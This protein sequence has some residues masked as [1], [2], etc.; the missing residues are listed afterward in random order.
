MYDVLIVGC[1]LTGMV[2][3]R[4]LAEEGL[5]V[6][7]V[8]RRDHIGGNMYDYKDDNGILVQKYGPHVFFTDNKDVEFFVNKYIDTYPFYPECRTVIE[9]TAIPM[10]FNFAS[11]DILYEKKIAEK[12]KAS[13]IAEFGVDSI[14]SVVDVINSKEE[15]VHEYG[16]FMYEHEYKKYSAKQWGRPI[17]SIDPSVFMRV[18]VYVSYKKPYLRQKFQYMPVGGFTE[19]AKRLID[20]SGISI[21]LGTDAINRIFIDRKRKLAV[22]D[23]SYIGPIVYTGPLDTLFKYQYGRLPYR[24]LEFTWKTVPKE[25]T[26]ETPLCA[27]P[28]ADKYI[29]ITDYTQFPPQKL[30]NKAV[31]AIEY[32]LEY[33]DDSLCGNEP[34]YPVLTKQSSNRYQ[35][36][37]SEA[38]SIS[39]LYACGRLADFKYYNMDACILKA[40]EFAKML[41]KK[42]G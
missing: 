7:I 19:F 33:Q 10:P 14:V 28:E 25:K 6:H 20:H 3:A 35:K 37:E 30:E 18:P 11:I 23:A 8:E 41:I 13:L 40:K 2:S 38:K 21:E 16:V 39:N 31:I 9:G 36:Y 17:D 26:I 12:L 32:P 22:F 34:Y 15:L 5:R 4:I 1:G 42:I 29:R 24:S 27:F